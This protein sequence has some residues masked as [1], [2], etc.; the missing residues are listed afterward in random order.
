[1]RVVRPGD[2][3]LSSAAQLCRWATRLDR[4]V[5]EVALLLAPYALVVACFAAF[6]R[7][8]GGIVLGDKANHEPVLHIP[9]MLY[10]YAYVVAAM[11]A[12]IQR[13]T[14]EHPFLLSDNRHYPFY[15]WKDIFRR[16][17]L[18]RYAAIPFYIYTISAVHRCICQNT[19][20]LWR[21]ALA[22]CTAAVLVPSPLLELRY[23][24][25]PYFFVRLHISPGP[26]TQA[27]LAEALWFSVVNAVTIW[28]FLRRPF[29]W[30]SEPGQL[31]RFM[32]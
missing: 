12:C 26:S 11:A 8:N 6:V 3:L 13:Y 15:L 29:V 27:V 9:Q 19:T 17:W 32:W 18:A 5:L 4:S 2:S 21:L 20:A 1:S 16:H 7:V 22:L 28:V 10:F 25:V 14:I 31:Q 30:E 23:F 24:T